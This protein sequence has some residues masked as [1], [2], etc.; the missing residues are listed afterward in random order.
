MPEVLSNALEKYGGLTPSADLSVIDLG[1]GD[2]AIGKAMYDKGFTNI[3][4]VDISS[5]M[6]EIAE[7]KGVYK[8]LKKANLLQSLPFEKETFDLSVTSAVT[9]YI[10][11]AAL[12]HW[13]PIVKKGG[14]MCIVHKASVWPKWT[15]EQEKLE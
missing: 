2:G 4:G 15:P 1:C 6:M 14:K 13:I 10:E 8:T 3:T 12:E 9:T 5:K 7:K 11:P